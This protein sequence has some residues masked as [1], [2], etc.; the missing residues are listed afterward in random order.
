M[1]SPF[2]DQELFGAPAFE[3]LAPPAGPDVQAWTD[4]Y[5]DEGALVGEAH[6]AHEAHDEHEEHQEHETPT[7]VDEDTLPLEFADELED[8]QDEQYERTLAEADE[9]HADGLEFEDELNAAEFIEPEA[10]HTPEA[11]AEEPAAEAQ[12]P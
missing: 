4:E 8:E 3:A 1:V 12:M 10:H 7:A 5:N 6:D 9:A 11:F 2:L